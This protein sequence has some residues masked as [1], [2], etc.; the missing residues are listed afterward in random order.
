MSIIQRLKEYYDEH[1]FGYT[2]SRSADKAAQVLL[3]TYDR[4]WRR[5]CPGP[6]ELERQRA[7]PPDA[8]LI[9]VVIPVYNTRVSW[10]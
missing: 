6:D 4:V 2:L 5:D 8:G 3:G 1:G 7:C 10:R 9:S